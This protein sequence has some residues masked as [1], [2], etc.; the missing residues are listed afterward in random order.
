[1]QRDW[2]HKYDWVEFTHFAPLRSATRLNTTLG[3]PLLPW[4]AGDNLMKH[5]LLHRT[6]LIR[7]FSLYSLASVLFLVMWA[8]AYFLL[9]EGVLRGRTGAQ[10]LAGSQAADS[11]LA[12][13]LRIAAINLAVGTVFVV[14]PNFVRSHGYPMGYATPLAWAII[15]AVYLGTNSFTFP[16]PEGKMPPSL[17]VLGRSGPYEIAAYILAAVATYSLPKYE[18]KGRWPRERIESISPAGR[19]ALTEERWLGLVVAVIVL[20]VASAWEAYQIVTRFS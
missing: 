16:L 14:G 4:N 18:I 15:Y 9:P 20:L 3:R 11:F 6:L 12:E 13:W 5:L 10:L 19:L 1:V 2:G 17:A 7:F 8:L